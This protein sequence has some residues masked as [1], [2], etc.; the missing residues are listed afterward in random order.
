MSRLLYL[1]WQELWPIAPTIDLCF[2]QGLCLDPKEWKITEKEDGSRIRA[3][4]GFW[5]FSDYYNILPERLVV[6]R[7]WESSEGRQVQ[8]AY[9]GYCHP[10]TCWV[11]AQRSVDCLW[12]RTFHQLGG[13]GGHISIP[14]AWVFSPAGEGVLPLAFSTVSFTV[15]LSRY[16]YVADNSEK[17]GTQFL[18]ILW[19]PTANKQY[20]I[21]R[22]K[23]SQSLCSYFFFL[24]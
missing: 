20:L 3:R 12:L 7:L 11:W 9:F 1:L 22:L 15:F 10:L 23:V 24:P 13:L 16:R 17:R 2:L 18:K 8:R 4:K 14:S 5:F 19:A 21:F 6:E